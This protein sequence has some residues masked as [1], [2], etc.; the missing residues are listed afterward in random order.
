MDQNNSTSFCL[1]PSSDLRDYMAIKNGADRS[2]YSLQELLAVV[3]HIIHSKGLERGPTCPPQNPFKIV[4]DIRNIIWLHYTGS[5]YPEDPAKN[6][7]S[8]LVEELLHAGLT[9]DTSAPH[10]GGQQSQVEHIRNFMKCLVPKCGFCH[11]MS[12]SAPTPCPSGTYQAEAIL[13]TSSPRTEVDLTSEPKRRRI[14]KTEVID[15]EDN[16]TLAVEAIPHPRFEPPLKCPQIGSGSIQNAK[17]QLWQDAKILFDQGSDENWITRNLAEA[18]G[19]KFLGIWEGNLTTVNGSNPITRRA[20]ELT[21]FNFKLRKPV[22]IQALVSES[23]M[24]NWK[25]RIPD[26][27]L[28]AICSSFG[29]NIEEVDQTTGVCQILIGYKLQSLQTSRSRRLR[30]N[31]YPEIRVY[32]SPAL[33]CVILVGQ[34]TDNHQGMITLSK[35]EPRRSLPEI[36]SFS[37]HTSSDKTFDTQM[38]EFLIAEKSIP[39]TDIQCEICSKGTDC[40]GCKSARSDSTFVEIGE[41][42]IIRRAL[43]IHKISEKDGKVINE[44]RIDYPTYVNLDKVYTKANCNDSMARQAS[45]SL[46]RKLVKGNK[47]EAFHEKVMESVEAGHVVVMTP[48]LIKQHSDLP[49]SYQ[50]VNVVYKDSSASTKVRVVTNSS[51]QRMGGSFNDCCLKG[52]SQMHSSLKILLGFSAF[53]FAFMSDLSTAY[54]SCKTKRLTNS[55]RRFFWFLNPLDETSLTE[56]MFV[57]STFGDKP[58]GNILGQ[59]LNIIGNDKKVSDDTRAFINNCFYVD[60][61]I[62]SSTTTARLL[63]IKKELPEAFARYSFKVKH[64]LLNFEES[65]GVTSENDK[66][67]CL[68]IIWNFT[69]DEIT[70]ALN[71]Y[72]SKKIRGAHV[73]DPMTLEGIAACIF[74][75]RIVLRVLG[76]LHDLCGRHL[77]P[78]ICSAR[79]CYGKVCKMNLEK[80]WDTPIKNPEV[81]DQVTNLFESIVKVKD[82]LLPMSRSWV[83][84]DSELSYTIFPLDGG[85]GAFGAIGYARSSSTAIK[86]LNFSN[87]MTA[88]CKVSNLDVGDNELAASL[89]ASRMAEVVHDSLPEP[90]PGVKCV[91]ITDSQCTAFCHNDSFNHTERRRRNLGVRFQR[92]IRRLH[93]EHD[94]LPVIL[95]WGRSETNSADLVSKIHPDIHEVLNSSFYRHGSPKYVEE[96][97][98]KNFSI[99]AYLTGQKYVFLG[100]PNQDQHLATC[101]FCQ[102][103]CTQT[104][105][106]IT[107]RLIATIQLNFPAAQ[108]GSKGQGQLSRLPAEHVLDSSSLE[109]NGSSP[110]HGLSMEYPSKDGTNFVTRITAASIKPKEITGIRYLLKKFSNIHSVVQAESMLLSWSRKTLLS[111]IRTRL[112]AWLKIVGQSQG[113]FEPHNIAQLLPVRFSYRGIHLIG[114][115]NRL[116][117]YSLVKYHELPIGVLPIIS[118]RDEDLLQCLLTLAHIDRSA[119]EPAEAHLSKVLTLQRLR[120]GFYGAIITQAS[121]AV[122]RFISQCTLCTKLKASVI[123][124]EISDKWI[125][126]LSSEQ[127]GLFHSIG[128]DILGP[129]RFKL[130][131]VTRANRVAKIWLLQATCQLTSGISFTLMEDYSSSSFI[132]AL[133]T[134]SRRTRYPVHIT[135]DSGSQLKAGLKRLTRSSTDTST[136]PEESL[137]GEFEDLVKDAQKHL[138]SVK[139]FVAHSNSQAINGLSE[140]NTKVTKHIL[141]S[142]LYTVQQSSSPFGSFIQVINTF[143]RI[144]SLLNSRAIFHNDSSVMS[145]KTLMFPSLGKSENKNEDNLT[146]NLEN[147]GVNGTKT[148]GI[149]NLVSECDSTHLEFTRLFCQSV[150]DST[151]QRFGKRATRKKNTFQKDDFI[152]IMVAAGVKYGLVNQVISNHTISARL[153]NKHRKIRSELRVEEFA[154]EQCTLLHRKIEA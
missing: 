31:D 19:C 29:M 148:K 133:E 76:S 93:N 79:I 87:I 72:L 111:D 154:S 75:Q 17:T 55:C 10:N 46:R 82:N 108:T 144:A 126:R 48:E 118:N 147:T 27:K 136:T 149:M 24:I 143:E 66:E 4:D 78:L 153:L 53:P 71:V 68:G 119:G 141:K 14:I 63:G 134:H 51:V 61:G 129:V 28:K 112:E 88:K 69:T 116:N 132:A 11:I 73:G 47:I 90:V 15:L 39:L 64:I 140:S 58:S 65:T 146:I 89:M 120:T 125:L 7:G 56:L 74:T 106:E 139:F 60:D 52:S 138:G 49:S 50:L 33:K 123:P 84:K 25:E 124:L 62:T 23:E 59:E 36:S 103:V 145:V 117:L 42:A 94:S 32:R 6:V 45:L 96:D 114:S 85:I 151:F 57:V 1:E 110:N 95:C 107:P 40:A 142:L 86:G 43:E 92:S 97:F 100:F 122:S 102:T 41:D 35:C 37:T 130:G 135:C 137:V 16:E 128:I 20:V 44:F 38:Q 70:P 98:P 54:R 22:K 83:P 3:E 2:E 81:Y 18:M 105:S 80:K 77:C 91:L 12:N 131:R 109:E 30:S 13:P 26:K 67:Q 8:A 99:Y 34:H 121:K 9:K 127:D 115:K 104:S 5:Q 152:L 150:R 21:I 101:G 113:M